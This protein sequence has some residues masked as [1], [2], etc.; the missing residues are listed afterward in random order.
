MVG[1][2]FEIDEIERERFKLKKQ[3]HI[4]VKKISSFVMANDNFS[5]HVNNYS[6][7]KEDVARVL[8]IIF[9]LR[10]L[11]FNCILLISI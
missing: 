8:K 2:E 7:L 10:E 4:I 3:L 5:N 9:T 11:V 1:D 6:R